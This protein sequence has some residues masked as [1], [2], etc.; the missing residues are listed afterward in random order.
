MRGKI[1]MCALSFLLIGLG[2]IDAVAQ[3]ILSLDCSEIASG[4]VYIDLAN[5]TDIAAVEM[6]VTFDKTAFSVTTIAKTS[7]TQAVDIFMFNQVATGVK[8]VAT[9]LGHS[10]A[11]G[12]G[13]IAAIAVTGTGAPN[14]CIATGSILA[15][16]LANPIPHTTKCCETPPVG[17]VLS[18]DCS[19]IADGTVYLDLANTDTIAAAE[20][21]ITFTAQDRAWND[22]SK[23]PANGTREYCLDPGSYTFTIDA[24]PPWNSTNGELVVNPGDRY[25]WPIN[26]G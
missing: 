19:E 5:T 22:S 24:P 25:R 14:W 1:L 2:S 6:T 7:R 15:D 3:T 10:I 17:N 26:P 13:H 18:L 20:L 11:A 23:V 8:L 21:T 16:A 4:T 9:G 12:S